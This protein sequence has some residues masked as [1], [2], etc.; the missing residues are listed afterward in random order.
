MK[1][2]TNELRKDEIFLFNRRAD[3]QLKEWEM[4]FKTLRRGKVA[5][6]IKGRKIAEDYCVPI[7]IHKSEYLLY[8]EKWGN[9][10]VNR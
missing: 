2:S 8:N 9:T 10:L 7:F 1:F 5:L 3:E 4:Q 6:D